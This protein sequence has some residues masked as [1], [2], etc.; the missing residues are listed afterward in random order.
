[1][2]SF[3]L[4]WN[5]PTEKPGKLSSRWISDARN[6]QFF[7]SLTFGIVIFLIY[8][9]SRF[10]PPSFAFRTRK[11]FATENCN[12]NK[13]FA[14]GNAVNI[15][16]QVNSNRFWLFKEKAKKKFFWLFKFS[17]LYFSRNFLKWFYRHFIIYFIFPF[18]FQGEEEKN[19]LLFINIFRLY[20]L[21]PKSWFILL[22]FH[23]LFRFSFSPNCKI[24]SL[25][26]KFNISENRE[27]FSHFPSS[28][29]ID[30]FQWLRSRKEGR[31]NFSLKSKIF[32]V[33]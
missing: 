3:T 24:F 17:L 4:R 27:N 25:P 16:N 30:D 14:L 22:F 9:T 1:M 33:E 5:L 21:L 2:N 32:P 29:I 26:K 28:P 11:M 31:K 13:L 23:S 6:V 8:P 10:L 18:I 12:W 20:F 7:I 15:H 19:N